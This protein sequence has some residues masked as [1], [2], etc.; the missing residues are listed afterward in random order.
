MTDAEAIEIELGDPL[1]FARVH[2][3]EPAPSSY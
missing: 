3:P 2:P 1:T